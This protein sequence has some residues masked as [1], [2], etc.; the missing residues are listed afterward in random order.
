[1]A[2][3]SDGFNKKI[4]FCISCAFFVFPLLDFVLLDLETLL[5]PSACL[6]HLFCVRSFT[7]EVVFWLDF[8]PLSARAEFSTR[9]VFP[10]TSFSSSWAS[11]H[12]S[13]CLVFFSSVLTS[14]YFSLGKFCF[15]FSSTET[16]PQLHQR[17]RILI[18]FYSH[19]LLPSLLVESPKWVFGSRVCLFVVKI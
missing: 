10:G 8:L 12:R 14:S 15:P 3:I 18:F 13:D 17:A 6:P 16:T 1:V 2:M 4:E 19:R 11:G 7:V 5:E 9:K